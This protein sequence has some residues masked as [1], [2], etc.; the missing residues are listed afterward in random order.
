MLT[1]FSTIPVF[2]ESSLLLTAN[3]FSEFNIGENPLVFGNTTDYQGNPIS[4]A[5]I[6]VGFPTRTI[7]TTTNETGQFYVKSP[8]IDEPGNYTIYVTASK[9]LLYTDTQLFFSVSENNGIN[10]L[11]GL[12]SFENKTPRNVTGP[13]LDL[14]AMMNDKME[15]QKSVVANNDDLDEDSLDEQRKVVQD[16]LEQD[17][18][19][20]EKKHEPNS[21]RNAFLRFLTGIDTVVKNLFWQ[22]FLFTEEITENAQ[23]AKQE[24]LNEGK[25]SVEATKVFQD[26][27]A[28]TKQEIIEFNKKLNIEH[29]NATNSTQ[30]KFNELG[31]IERG[32]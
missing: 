7:I 29:A 3:S 1:G 10:S 17:M 24:A 20:F 9:G 8:A 30:E 6:Q 26:E 13:K 11:S 32:D 22:Q 31:K 27:A 4:D 5:E 28:V 23:E 15:E 16:N 25:T 12:E 14:L 18:K 21:P 2:A 19:S